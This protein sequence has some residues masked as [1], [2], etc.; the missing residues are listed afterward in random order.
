MRSWE[1]NFRILR[2]TS[3]ET[4][5][6]LLGGLWLLS[7]RPRSPILMFLSYSPMSLT[8]VFALSTAQKWGFATI[9]GTILGV[10]TITIIIHC[11]ILGSPSLRKLP[12]GSYEN[13][14]TGT[15]DSDNSPDSAPRRNPSTI[16]LLHCRCIAASACTTLWIL[17]TKPLWQA[18]GL[19]KLESDQPPSAKKYA[20]R[21]YE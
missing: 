21:H 15:C 3:Y 11:S 12:H 6:C 2:R 4:P 7:L 16:L 13:K 9:R 10:P 14:P 18:R 5:I 8:C 20:P 19:S 17:G 1:Q